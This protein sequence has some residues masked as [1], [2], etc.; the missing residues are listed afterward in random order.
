MPMLD[1]PNLERVAYHEAGHT[2]AFL[3]FGY[4]PHYASILPDEE[5]GS[6]GQ[7]FQL[8]CDD[9]TVEGMR[10][11]V[12]AFYAGAESERLICSPHQHED[13]DGRAA[14]D[15][16]EAEWC[17]SRTG[18]TEQELRDET[19][20]FVTANWALIELI[21]GELM[22]HKE[23]GWDELGILLDVYR[24]KASQEDLAEY[25]CSPAH[26]LG[27]RPHP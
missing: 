24:G 22:E 4:N 25:R 13:V 18:S 23:L 2:A 19:V 16:E 12:I 10:N 3:L 11:Q 26:L 6:A 5:D 27:G 8:D 7:A 21:A 17:L 1:E 14:S 9:C 15:N 20:R